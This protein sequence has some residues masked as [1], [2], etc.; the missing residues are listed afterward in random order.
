MT[1]IARAL[2]ALLFAGFPGAAVAAGAD[3]SNSAFG[4]TPYTL[5]PT[6]DLAKL[7]VVNVTLRN[8]GDAATNSIPLRALDETKELSGEATVSPIAPGA[9]RDVQLLM[10]AA[11][12]PSAGTHVITVFFAPLRAMKALPVQVPPNLC[13]KPVTPVSGISEGTTAVRAATAPRSFDAQ[14]DARMR[15]A[16]L[17]RLPVRTV[18]RTQRVADPNA[19]VQD[20]G[21]AETVSH[22]VADAQNFCNYHPLAIARAK[23]DVTPG[24]MITL[25]GACFGSVSGHARMLGQFPGGTVDLAVRSWTDDS[26]TAVVPAGLSGIPDLP[27]DLVLARARPNRS[28]HGEIVS[29]PVRMRFIAARETTLSGYRYLNPLTCVGGDTYSWDYIADRPLQNACGVGDAWGAALGNEGRFGWASH[30]RKNGT[31]DSGIDRWQ[32]RLPLG[33]R[34]DSLGLQAESAESSVDQTLDPT[35]VTFTVSW[36]TVHKKYNRTYGKDATFSEYEDGSY[37][38]YVYALAPRGL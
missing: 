14:A 18:R 20:V 32:L 11:A 5:S 26:V 3:L 19:S 24:G 4:A 1:R 38:V 30:M 36:R 9:S 13:A 25:T 8:S 27:V 12:P 28:V 16:A 17:K 7:V 35:N 10:H 37:A 15:F 2:M 23:G 31:A 29:S 34:F 6:C 33:W 22:A 21:V